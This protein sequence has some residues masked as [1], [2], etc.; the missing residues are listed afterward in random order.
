MKGKLVSNKKVQNV[1]GVSGILPCLL[2]RSHAGAKYRLPSRD[3]RL[4]TLTREE[5]LV[6]MGTCLIGSADRLLVKP[7]WFHYYH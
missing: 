2:R 4:S 5:V 1:C 7:L 3:A 6:E